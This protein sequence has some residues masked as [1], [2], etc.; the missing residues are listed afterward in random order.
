MYFD[1]VGALVADN[2]IS[3]SVVSVARF[4]KEGHLVDA[5]TEVAAGIGAAHIAKHA[6]GGGESGSG[7]D[8]FVNTIDGIAG[9]KAGTRDRNV[10]IVCTALSYI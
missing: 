2:L 4:G 3:A 10:V 5:G 8:V 7:V 9:R 6:L 1:D